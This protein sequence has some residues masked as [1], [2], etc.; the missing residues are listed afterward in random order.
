[1]SVDV[2]RRVEARVERADEAK[3]SWDGQEARDGGVSLI[4]ALSKETGVG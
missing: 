1:M 2:Q 3:E 4:A